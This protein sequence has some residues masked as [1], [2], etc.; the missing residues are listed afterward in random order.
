MPKGS[1]DSHN[2]VTDPIRYPPIP[3]SAYV[4]GV[5][6]IWDQA[7]FEHGIGCEHTV[8]IQP[9]LYGTDNSMLLDS[10]TAIGPDRGRGVVVFDV[11]NITDAEL[12]HW[13]TLGVRGVRINFVSNDEVPVAEDLQEDLRAFANV[14][15]GL[16]WV[17]QLYIDMEYIPFIEPVVPDLGVQV[18]LDHFGNPELPEPQSNCSRN[19]Y[20]PYSLKGFSS[21]VNLLNQGNTWV[22]VSGP[23]RLSKLPGP[24]YEDLDPVALELFRIAPSKLVYAS[25]W[26]HTRFEGLDIKPWT[27]HILDLT[28]GD[29]DVREKLFRDNAVRLWSGGV[30]E[31]VH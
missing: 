25:D 27:S 17:I 10:L 20:D 19:S 18:V 23:Y 28:E 4:P 24:I 1:W 22:K 14:V 15:K 5:H 16:G 3:D 12:E 6:T 26:P 21:M 29:Q 2:H 7:I 8:M 31:T 13:H 9:S 11:N 30:N